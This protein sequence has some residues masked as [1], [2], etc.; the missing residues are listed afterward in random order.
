MT[1]KM[2][3]SKNQVVTTVADFGTV[4]VNHI[5]PAVLAHELGHHADLDLG[6]GAYR[7]NILQIP[8]RLYSNSPYPEDITAEVNATTFAR[9]AMGPQDWRKN[10]KFLTTALASYLYGHG[11]QFSKPT[12]GEF[13]KMK[14]TNQFNHDWKNTLEKD[15]RGSDVEKKRLAL[16]AAINS[17][18]QKAHTAWGK[19]DA[20]V[21]EDALGRLTWTDP[22][23][24]DLVT[25]A[26]MILDTESKRLRS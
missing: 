22:K 2:S 21:R 19:P 23:T 18:S 17:I 15:L 4:N 24:Q 20:P 13:F 9:K 6:K 7:S 3:R 5:R 11:N 16:R 14:P 8:G 26:K 25:M 1:S 12:W 10:S